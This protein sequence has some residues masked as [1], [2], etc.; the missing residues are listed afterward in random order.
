[1]MTWNFRLFGPDY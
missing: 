1:M